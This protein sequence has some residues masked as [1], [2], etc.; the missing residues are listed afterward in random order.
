M[1]P[2]TQILPTIRKNRV[3]PILDAQHRD[4]LVETLARPSGRRQWLEYKLKYGQIDLSG[5]EFSG[6]AMRDYDLSDI[7]MS[8]SIFLGA[9][10]AGTDFSDGYLCYADLRRANLRNGCLDRTD[11]R[12]AILNEAS[13]VDACLTDAFLKGA[14][15]A[16][17]DLTG[18][19]L[20]GANLTGAD[21]RGASLKFARLTGA[22]LKGA[23]FA[24]ANLTGTVLDE[25]VG[26]QARNWKRSIVETR[27]Y[28]AM[29]RGRFARL[30]TEQVGREL[31]ILTPGG[32][33]PGEAAVDEE[34][35][36][37]AHRLREGEFEVPH[38]E[39]EPDLESTAGCRQVLELAGDASL[40][41]IVKAFRVK[42]KLYHPDM[43][44]HLSPKIQELASLE[45]QRLHKAYQRLTRSTTRH[46]EGVVW[47]DGVPHRDSPYEYS[48]EEYERLAKLNPNNLSI[49]YNLGWKYFEAER[50]GEA[51]DCFERVLGLDEEDEDARYNLTICRICMELNNGL[52]PG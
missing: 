47:A 51:A 45:F 15:L 24:E 43:V 17:A 6:I 20:T 49:F 3:L 40:E 21:L 5:I 35:K 36:G 27:Q 12:Q 23:N 19:D 11:L 50:H 37:R 18:A 4:F 44:R 52:P 31:V 25:G 30:R 41:Q 8:Q 32:R 22:I 38:W 39:V 2:Q 28:K 14:H 33:K 13:L 16:G 10:L 42:A 34:K 1:P 7:N 29:P 9:D 46:L 48:C 26:T